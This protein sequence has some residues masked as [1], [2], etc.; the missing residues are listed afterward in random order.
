MRIISGKARSITLLAPPGDSLRPTEDR[1]KEVLFATL[2][3]LSQT[4]FVDLFSGTGALGLEALSRGA[5]RVVMVER[6][7]E[8]LRFLEKNLAA[9][10]KSMAGSEG[11]VQVLQADV[12]DLPKLLPQWTGSAKILVA[13]PPYRTPPGQFG[14]P[15]LLRSPIHAD[16]AGPDSQLVLE[17][18]TAL[19]LPW[20]PAG[21][22]KPCRQKTF[23]IR[24][25]TYARLFIPT[26]LHTTTN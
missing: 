6:S 16:W 14:A 19:P 3:N 17:H 12:A 10:R 20:A 2:G 23:G 18:E 4:T 5:A 11:Q 21:P 15:E 13:D 24:T 9:V 8:H 25:L 22:W 1:V 26:T 7:A